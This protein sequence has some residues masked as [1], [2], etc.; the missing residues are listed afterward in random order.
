MRA[1][2]IHGSCVRDGAWWWSRVAT[3]LQAEGMDSVAVRL[4]SCGETGDKPGLDGPGLD[5][6]VAELRRVL[7][8]GDPAVVVGHSYG[9]VVATEA[10]RAGDAAHLMFVTSVLP[11]VGESLASFGGP[12]P[13]PFLDFSADGT[14]GARAEM[15]QEL[16][17]QD[18][19]QEAVDGAFARL[20][21]QTAA[22]VTQPVRNAGWK[23]TPTTYLVCASDLATPP[24]MQRAQ[25]AR[26]GRVIELP[27]G[28]HP[29]LSHPELVAQA[30]LAV[31]DSVPDHGVTDDPGWSRDAARRR[32]G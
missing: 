32:D 15:L 30:I 1:V 16:F 23:H 28:H 8:Q 9:G 3:L 4:P 29:F 18:C 21:R 19:D 5:A 31:V 11:E 14:F 27:A 12:E 6:D 25:A 24:A 22:V 26:A 2:F 13:A 10:L 17:L 20:T 7:S